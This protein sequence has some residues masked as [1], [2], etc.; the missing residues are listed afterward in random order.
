M[1]LNPDMTNGAL[2]VSRGLQQHGDGLA[3]QSTDLAGSR[4][5]QPQDTELA[6]A[7]RGA[8]AGPHL[9]RLTD[10]LLRCALLAEVQQRRPEDVSEALRMLC[11]ETHVRGLR[12]EQLLGVLKARW[13]RLPEAHVT[14]SGKEDALFA[15]VITLCIREYYAQR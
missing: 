3:G 2:Q 12:A 4:G 1:R 13:R 6:G 5:M 7:G 9:E 15:R 10:D 8:F 11:L 14:R